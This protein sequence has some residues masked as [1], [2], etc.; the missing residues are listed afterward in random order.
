MAGSHHSTSLDDQVLAPY[1]RHFW[2]RQRLQPPS[3]LL[4]FGGLS[5]AKW[6]S[7]RHRVRARVSSGSQIIDCNY[8]FCNDHLFPSFTQITDWHYVVFH[9]PHFQLKLFWCNKIQT[10][11]GSNKCLFNTDTQYAN[12]QGNP[13]YQA[14]KQH[15]LV[16]K[17]KSNCQKIVTATRDPSAD[18]REIARSILWPQNNWGSWAFDLHLC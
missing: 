10:Q 4:Q 1:A 2:Q 14:T 18:H 8:H 17:Y 5:V 11:K 6:I 7:Q 16:R 15:F 13:L 3:L 12:F 9:Q